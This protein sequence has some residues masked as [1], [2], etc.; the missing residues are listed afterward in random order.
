MVGRTTIAKQI[1]VSLDVASSKDIA[2]VP[3]Q[4]SVASTFSMLVY[5]EKR[6]AICFILWNQGHMCTM[7][8]WTVI[9]VIWAG[10]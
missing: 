5:A 9:S 3:T 7:R 2:G 8:L 1:A 10:K 4:F 6:T